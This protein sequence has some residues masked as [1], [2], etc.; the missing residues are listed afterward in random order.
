L[1][2]FFGQD[3][4]FIDIDTIHKGENF[5][6]ALNEALSQCCVMLV[7]IG[8]RWLE[9][10][11]DL[12][13]RRLDNP[14]DYVRLE[15]ETGLKRGIP[16]VPVLVDG[17][18]VP[19]PQQLPDDL[20]GLSDMQAAIIT[21]DNFSS[22]IDGLQRAL[23]GIVPKRRRPYLWAAAFLIVGVISIFAIRQFGLIEHWTGGK[24]CRLE[25][26]ER[27]PISQQAAVLTLRNLRV[28]PIR[29]FWISY[30]GKREEYYT[31]G[32]DRS[33]SQTT[34]VGH[35]WVATDMAENCL[36]V[37]VLNAPSAEFVVR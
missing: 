12:G 18:A 14:N 22:D 4:I 37:F 6:T 33:H 34:F 32:S 36:G 30:A 13:R 24:K 20:K 2:H 16:L 26:S 31:L 9:A 7:V 11:D 29:I 27:S 15:I 19:P 35:I 25:L 10:Q 17:A 5:R 21:H 1:E 8:P 23:T 28:A 3:Q